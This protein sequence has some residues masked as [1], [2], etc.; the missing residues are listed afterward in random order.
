MADGADDRANGDQ[1][2]PQDRQEQPPVPPAGDVDVAGFEAA[3][4]EGRSQPPEALPIT[5][6]RMP[7]LTRVG[8]TLARWVLV[9][10]GSALLILILVLSVAEFETAPKRELTYERAL[11]I[12]G[13]SLERG[14]PQMA[15]LSAQFAHA[16]LTPAAVISDQDRA[17][18]QVAI[19]RF[20]ARSDV[21]ETDKAALK[22]CWPLPGV[23]A[24]GRGDLLRQCADIVDRYAGAQGAFSER[25]KLVEGL[26][27]QAA[28]ERVAFRTFWL[29]M[30]QM[31][32]LNLFLPLLTALLGYI[33]GSQQAQKG[34][35]D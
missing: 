18:A 16:A 4:R 5:A 17:L 34:D 25:V 6:Q 12:A 11:S 20:T 15:W 13:A 30:A 19:D 33:F 3:L 14:D 2:A 7:A 31:I 21:G 9:L 27:K 1:P 22:A 32:L 29:Q 8:Y 23:A 24:A 26:Q 28:D 35:P 10:T